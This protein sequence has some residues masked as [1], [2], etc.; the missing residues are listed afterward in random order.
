MRKMV[1]VRKISDIRP[2]ENADAIVCARVGGWDVVTK[3]GEFE[4]GDDC[5]YFEID[6]FLPENDHRFQFLMSNKIKWQG[7]HGARLKTIKLRGQVSQ[8]LALPLSSFPEVEQQFNGEYQDQDFAE[9]L[10]VHKWEPIIPAQLAG[11]IRS[12][13]PSFIRKTDQERCQNIE[14]KIFSNPARRYEVTTKLE[15]SSFTAYRNDGD[16]GVCSRNMNLKL[17]DDGNAFVKLFETSLLKHWLEECEHR[18]VAIQGEMMGPGVQG[19]IEHLSE[20]EFFMFDVFLID[21]YRYMTPKERQDYFD[22]VGFQEECAASHVPI[23]HM[24][25]TLEELGIT[26][27]DQLIAFADG[28]SINAKYREGLVF[29]DMDSEFSFKAISNKYLLKEK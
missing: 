5:V 13:F 6:S 12:T 9:L 3:K 18:N 24:N 7:H 25:V 23:L 2:I 14:D 21:E 11:K 22:Y 28:P 4:V 17:D 8:G 27:L 20:L 19:N 16:I 15:G 1:T 10:S 26:N 29:K